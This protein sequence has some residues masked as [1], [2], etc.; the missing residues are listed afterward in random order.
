MPRTKTEDMI[1]KKYGKLTVLG[2]DHYKLDKDGYKRY[3]LRC[4]CDCGNEKVVIA[5]SLTRG[6]TVSCGCYQKV[7]ASKAKRTHGKSNSRIYHIFRDM[8]RRCENSQRPSYKRYGGRG[9][10]VCD[11]WNKENGFCNFYD[12]SMTNGYADELTIDRIDNDKGYSPDNCRWVDYVTQANNTSWNKHIEYN[13]E[14][15]TM[16]EWGRIR[17]L[18]P[19]TIKNRLNHGWSVS[20]ALG[21]DEHVTHHK[22]EVLY[23]INGETHNI[24]DWCRIQNL[25]VDTVRYRREHNWAPEEIF[26]FKEHMNGTK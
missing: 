7:A 2:I 4:K 3:Y 22:D 19:S 16:A 20:E 17:S 1:G 21:F 26:G 6:L 23:T 12:W 24:R 11:E 8:H 18:R 14:T 15:H 9:I 5:Y 25:S 10:T 13:N